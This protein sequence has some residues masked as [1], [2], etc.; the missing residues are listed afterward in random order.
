MDQKTAVTVLLV[1]LVLS[2]G[3]TAASASSDV[4][5]FVDLQQHDNLDR[6]AVSVP[7]VLGAGLHNHSNL[8]DQTTRTEIN[9]YIQ[10]KPGIHFRGICSSL[11]LS[12]G[13]VQY[14]LYVLE[15]GGYIT[16]YIDG[17]NKRY[18]QADTFTQ[19]EM[20]LVSLARHQTAG[21]ILTLLTQNSSMLHRDIAEF[22]GVSSQA[23][24]WQMNQLKETGLVNAEKE[25][26]NV[27]YTL[28]NPE[29]VNYA[30]KIVSNSK[31]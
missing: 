9:S 14:H 22:L 17:Q 7:I 1:A 10:D 20:A 23:L 18:F 12:V 6:L 4:P 19:K 27:K 15:K 3:V 11:G 29:H 31:N 25:S 2:V 16:S 30:L 26:I 21:E 5:M 8:L 13:V 28:T 24:T